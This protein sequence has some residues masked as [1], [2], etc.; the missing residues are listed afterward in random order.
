MGPGDWPQ[1]NAGLN[2]AS[3]VLLL[4]GYVAIKRRHVRLH[5]SCMLTA[6]CVSTLFL[7]SYLYY[8]IVV[9]AGRHTEFGGSDEARY[10]YLGILLSH[11]ILAAAAAPLALYTAYQGLSG[12]L[13]RHVKVARWTL[14][15][16][17]YVSVT[18]VV[19]YLMLRPYYNTGE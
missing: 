13:A 12:Q 9:R 8:H 15:I 19:V 1:L 6:L 14:P 2:A 11:T 17:F 5:T 4:V 10:V 3:A 16:W 7:A 18:G